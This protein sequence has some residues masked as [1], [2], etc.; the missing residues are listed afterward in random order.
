MIWYEQKKKK[1]PHLCKSTGSSL[2]S[3][4]SSSVF[5]SSTHLEN[6]KQPGDSGKFIFNDIKALKISSLYSSRQRGGPIFISYDTRQP[7]FLPENSNRY[8]RYITA[9][10]PTA[11]FG[12][13][14]WVKTE[15][16]LICPGQ[17][18]VKQYLKRRVNATYPILRQKCVFDPWMH[19]E[20]KVHNP[21]R[22]LSCKKQCI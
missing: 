22:T 15:S 3:L 7:K 6:T 17:I 21:F 5:L 16:N 8:I 19:G 10:A 1:G 20:E 13:D 2:E 4:F 12:P 14:I 11:F 9:E 18:R